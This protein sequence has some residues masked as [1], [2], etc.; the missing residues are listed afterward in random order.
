MGQGNL[1]LDST[2]AVGT[3][4]LETLERSR[5]LEEMLTPAQNTR[6]KG[7]GEGPV[8]HEQAGHEQT[9]FKTTRYK[10]CKEWTDRSVKGR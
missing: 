5:E 3:Q 6:E 8:H 9:L 1:V 2:R 4:R 7:L 10:K